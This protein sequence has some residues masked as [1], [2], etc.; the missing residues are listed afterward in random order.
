MCINF[1]YDHDLK[2]FNSE[3]CVRFNLI[4]I[5]VMFGASYPFIFLNILFYILFIYSEFFLL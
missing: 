3:I 4:F 5:F 2:M 1:D